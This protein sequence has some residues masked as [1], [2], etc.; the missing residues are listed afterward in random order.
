MFC[1]H[2]GGGA[3]PANWNHWSK[4]VRTI[5]D[6]GFANDDGSASQRLISALADY[7][8]APAP[9]S[10]GYADVLGVLQA[11]RLLVPVVAML[12][13]VEHDAD[14]HAHEKSSDV[15]TVLDSMAYDGLHD[16]FT[17]QPMGALTEHRN[18]ERYFAIRSTCLSV[19][20][21]GAFLWAGYH[22]RDGAAA[23]YFGKLDVDF[24]FGHRRLVQPGRVEHVIDQRIQSLHV[25][26]HEAIEVGL[27]L[28]GHAAT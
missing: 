25:V 1:F 7:A 6:A 14:G 5:P 3:A 9:T 18:R 2:A 19:S 20:M 26:E 10:R 4:P 21:L 17:D 8:S 24:V 27:L 12:G 23:Q 28:L 15:A 13:D 11:E 22:L 16:V